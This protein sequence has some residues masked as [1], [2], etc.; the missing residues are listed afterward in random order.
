M[1][2]SQV[3]PRYLLKYGPG[4][5]IVDC[6]Q[7]E[8]HPLILAEVEMNSEKDFI[9]VPNWCVKEITGVRDLSNASL[10]NSPLSNWQLD[11]R[12]NVIFL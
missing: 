5:W 12:K 1:E 3:F 10:A 6:F 8:N 11:D 7:G 9:E 2:M 4:E